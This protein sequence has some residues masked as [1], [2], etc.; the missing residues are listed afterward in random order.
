MK[1]RDC[2]FLSGESGLTM[3]VVFR[4]DRWEHTCTASKLIFENNVL[5]RER[6]HRENLRAIIF[7]ADMDNKQLE[8]DTLN[9]FKK[10][11]I[12]CWPNVDTLINMIDRHAV[13]KQCVDNNFVNHNIDQ[14]LYTDRHRCHLEYPFVV[15]CGNTHR[16]YDKFLIQSKSDL[17]SIQPWQNIATFEPYFIGDS[18]RALIVNNRIFGIKI[19]NE[20]SWIKNGPGADVTCVELSNELI[21]HALD[22]ANLSKLEIAGV[23]YIIEKS[24]KFHFLEINQFPGLSNISE[25]CTFYTEKFLDRKMQEL[26]ACIKI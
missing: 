17:D 20:S 8:L 11:N 24:G 1:E 19:D 14:L 2:L 16:G 21:Q 13:L 9:L 23:D 3:K 25:E 12:P 22:C 5:R 18:I 15:K 10:N 26:E 4:R 6:Y 7:Y